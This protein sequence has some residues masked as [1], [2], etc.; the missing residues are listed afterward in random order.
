MNAEKGLGGTGAQVSYKIVRRRLIKAGL[1][2]CVAAE[3]P[4]LTLDHRKKR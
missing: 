1:T 3:R 4:L 2:G